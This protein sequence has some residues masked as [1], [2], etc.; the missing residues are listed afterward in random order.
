MKKISKKLIISKSV[1]F[2]CDFCNSKFFSHSKCYNFYLKNINL[3]QNE[4]LVCPYGYACIFGNESILCS[5]VDDTYCDLNLI[6][7]RN[8]Y[9]KRNN[10]KIEI[11]RIIA[12]AEFEKIYNDLK[13]D[14]FFHVYRDT[15][16]DLNNNNRYLIDC[17][18]NIPI[19]IKNQNNEMN[20]FIDKLSNIYLMHKNN[21]DNASTD[22][23]KMQIYKIEIEKIDE[24]NKKLLTIVKHIDDSVIN[25]LKRNL[26]F[27]DY[28][29]RY[30]KRIV[31]LD[32]D[33][34]KEGYIKKLKIMSILT[35][36]KYVFSNPANK[37][38]QIIKIISNL[39]NSDELQ[40]EAY[41]DLYIAFFILYENA[42]KY[43]PFDS[44][45]SILIDNCDGYIKVKISNESD[46][47]GDANLLSRG[48]QGKNKKDGNGLGLTI[49][50]EIFTASKFDFNVY[51]D[52][53]YFNA[54][55]LFE[56][57]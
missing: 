26:E 48:V 12:K 5:I 27:I 35:K 43:A 41:D 47:I 56:K 32:G 14:T 40:T 20:C 49:A 17:Y 18:D 37:K 31:D 30:L 50:N 21:I 22:S 19:I 23:E 25:N 28:R 33:Y 42:I 16:H 7:R 4:V 52:N 57:D 39:N 24:Y 55:V 9:A 53:H 45:I 34:H 10:Q 51:Y 29:I 36:L 8:M 6:R 2:N 38:K 54:E 44:I 46:D 15:F 3:R 13:N 1:S 11:E